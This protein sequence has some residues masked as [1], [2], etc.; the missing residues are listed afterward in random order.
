MQPTSRKQ[1]KYP[2][3]INGDGTIDSICARCFVT[4][5]TS[6]WESELERME[7]MHVCEAARLKYFG[8]ERRGVDR[9]EENS[10]E[11]EPQ[12]RGGL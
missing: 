1:A 7:A 4:I 9:K 6:T 3:R 10:I 8:E 2:H 5:G 11:N 12:F